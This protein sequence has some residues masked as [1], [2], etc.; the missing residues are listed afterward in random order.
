MI[1]I[2]GVLIILFNLLIVNNMIVY[3]KYVYNVKREMIKI[4][5]YKEMDVV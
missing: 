2:K 5:F 4:K 1:I 3:N